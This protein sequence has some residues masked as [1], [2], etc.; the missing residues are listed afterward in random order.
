[1][2]QRPHGTVFAACPRGYAALSFPSR[3]GP[4]PE[5]DRPSRAFPPLNVRTSLRH[6]KRPAFP[7][8]R[9]HRTF[10]PGGNL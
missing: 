2:R 5:L 1:L 6:D 9:D 10:L 8:A 7:R 4:P 3:G